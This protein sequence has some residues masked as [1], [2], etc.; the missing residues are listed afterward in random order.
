MVS[1]ASEGVV[2]AFEPDTIREELSRIEESAMFSAQGQFEQ[3]KLWRSLNFLLGVPASV[4]AAVSGATALASTAGR[5]TAGILALAA[6]ALGAVL[7]T[8]NAAQR[9]SQAA[10]AANGYLAIQRDARQVRLIDLPAQ[11]VK[12][13]RAALADLTRRLTDQDKTADPPH[14]RAYLKAK[15][16]IGEGGQTYA[17]DERRRLPP[18]HEAPTR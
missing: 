7:T 13:S 17:A 12:D 8:V 9:A 6:A 14:R 5:V 18:G 1:D 15:A 10:I 4:L 11:S 2:P 16:N 3:A